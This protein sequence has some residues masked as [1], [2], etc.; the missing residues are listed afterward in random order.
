MESGFSLSN[1]AK[2]AENMLSRHA[3]NYHSFP[4]IQLQF[5]SLRP[6]LKKIVSI[7]IKYVGKHSTIKQRLLVFT[8]DLKVNF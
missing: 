2:R 5:T 7:I 6:I 8:N 3:P 1:G 4:D